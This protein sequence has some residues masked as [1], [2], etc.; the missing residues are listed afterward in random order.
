[1]MGV[2]YLWGGTS[3]KGMDC[4]GYTKT[5]YFLNGVLLPRDASQQIRVGELVETEEEM[6]QV[7]PGDLV[8]F[9]SPA[10][11][12]RKER[13]WH[14]GISLGGTRFIHAAGDVRINSLAPADSDYSGP[15]ARTFLRVKRVIGAGEESGVRR[16]AQV[17]YYRGNED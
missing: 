1:F 2:P 3:A 4:S 17:P 5:V 16:L 8:F 15:R 7:K 14:V 13:V 11:E 10:T 6:S 9:G 12:K